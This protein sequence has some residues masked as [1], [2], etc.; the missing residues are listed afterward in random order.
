VLKPQSILRTTLIL[1]TFGTIG[2]ADPKLAVLFYGDVHS[3]YVAR[4]LAGMGVEVDSC[5]PGKLAERL[6]SGQ[7]NVVVVS[8]MNDGER[9][10]VDE[11]I[12]QGGGVF[13]CNPENYWSAQSWGP[14]NEWLAKLG[15]RPRWELLQ[16]IDEGNTAR[17][18][19][20][21]RLSW[22]SQVF[23]PVSEGVKGVL[24][25]VWAST[26]G[27]EPPMSIDFGP[28]WTVT[29]RGAASMQGKA[30]TRHD[31]PLQPWMSK[32]LAKASPA[33]MGVR[34]VGKGRLAV[35][36]IRRHWL[37]SSPPN[38]PTVE[39]ML[40]AGAGG[41]PSDWLRV[42]ANTFRWL[43]EPS[44]K[45]GMGGA[46]TPDAVVNPPVTVWEPSKVVPWGDFEPLQN[47]LQLK[48][49]VGAR[50]SLSSGSGSV[51]D[52]VKQAKAAGLGFIVFLEDSL[53]MD[54]AGW[55]QLVEQ[56]S[57]A[58]DDGFLAVPGLTYENAQGDHH[59]AFADSVKFPK[60]EM[61]LPDRRLATTQR[62][63]SRS[64]FDYDNEYMQQKAIRGFWNH[65][66]NFLH[67]ADYKLYNAFAIVSFDEQRKQIDNALDEF[68]YL[69]GI[70]GCQ[71]A[72]AFEFLNRPEQVIERARDGWK[73]VSHRDLKQLNGNWHRGAFSFS[74]SGSQYITNGPSILAWDS[75][76]RLCEPRGE[77]WRP[78]Q[79]E[80]R[81][82]LRVAS[83][84]GL[85]TVTVYDGDRSVFRRWTP[86]GAK[87][88]EQQLVLSNGQQLGLTLVVEDMQ[89]RKA[90][91]MSFW[92]RNLNNEEFFCS[93]RC[94]FLG[95]ARLRTRSGQ[96]VWTQ[97]SFQANMGI[98]PSKGR[99]DMNAAPAVNLTLNSPTLPVDGAPAGFPTKTLWFGPH[100]PGE[101]LLWAYPQTYLV[102]PEI[103][104]GQADIA[105]GFDP[106]EK[107]AE[108]S[109]L[110][111]PYEQPQ[112]GWGNAWGGWHRLIPTRKVTG[113][114]RTYACTWLTE[115]FRIGW[116][117][118]NLTAKDSIDTK[119]KGI[120]MVSANGTL[121]RGGE[122]VAAP[123]S[124]PVSG[125]FSRGTFATLEDKGGSVVLIGTGDDIAYEYNKGN[126]VLYYRPGKT[127]FAKGDAIRYSVAFAGASAGTTTA[128][129]VE[130]AQK[131][132]VAK[133]GTTGYAPR[134][135]SGKLIDYYLVWRLDGQGKGIDASVAK[136]DMPGFLPLCVENLNDNWS[137]WLL[138]RARVKPNYRGLPIRDGRAWAQLD[139][140]L[141]DSDIFMG[142]PV[143]A[144]NAQV[145]LLVSWMK[146]GQWF[147]E[148]HNPTDKPIKA[149][150]STTTGWNV[151]QFNQ[152]INLLPGT[153]QVWSVDDAHS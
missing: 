13:I 117:E 5:P 111:H 142:H 135:K 60:P 97:V 76:G 109:P 87:E 35:V 56:C 65:K 150:L 15:A 6:T 49:L 103:G 72:L 110:G 128:K 71:S 126:L 9:K 30:E 66:S 61:L 136:A 134:L 45:S 44:I 153:S 62:M 123:E 36:G 78:D 106:A 43:A 41:K 57:A 1:V 25:L 124:G 130:F 102:S 40:T 116:F 114:A 152:A 33:L 112:D 23:P 91:S 133:P 83:E 92:N 69:Q 70:G 10:A 39:A 58:S 120:V 46:V 89:G 28:E 31:E 147:I 98:T 88:F 132:G 79:W 144:S 94:N 131:F 54:Q 74:G 22:S 113:W 151:F 73:V 101:I 99:L 51:G 93:D 140:N 82:R 108:K 96:Q 146:D 139:L 59:F 48:G 115:T 86:A 84:A 14:T 20:G 18:V 68:L 42:F 121:W 77:W 81:L 67:F 16:D 64:F 26:T 11:F 107:G 105:L 27:L 137:A 122:I 34:E 24:T 95:N 63:R 12:A 19:M 118:V 37:F 38:C 4:P 8:T 149:I 143:T 127:E 104:I 80:Y 3:G 17:D 7:Y 90:I 52:Y 21:C 53:K 29:V 129:M 85:K 2:S 47:Q 50:T 145:K 138:D 141:A 148:A 119:G 125:A 32:E 100:I 55:D 75:P